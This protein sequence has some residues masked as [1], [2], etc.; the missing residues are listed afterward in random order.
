MITLQL[1][2]KPLHDQKVE[3]YVVFCEQDALLGKHSGEELKRF[4]PALKDIIEKRKFS[5]R[6]GSSLTLAGNEGDRSVML[7]F[8]GLGSKNRPQE[9]RIETYRRALGSLIRACEAAKISTLALDLPD[10]HWFDCDA[11]TIAKETAIITDMA[12]YHFDL[13]ITDADA[14]PTRN[15]EI[16]LCA[17]AILHDQLQEGIT[18]GQHIGFAVRQAR[19]WCDLPANKLNPVIMAEHAQRIAQAHNLK[20]TVFNEEQIIKMGMGGIAAV[21]K[22]SELDAALVIMEYK[23]EHPN[24]PT[25]ALVGK[26]ITFDTGGISIKPS[27]GMEAMKDDMA[28]AAAVIS[29]M[30]ALAHLKPQVNVIGIAPLAENMPSGSA[31]RPGDIITFYNGKTG[32]VKNT[33]AEGRLI[34]A[35]ALSYA[36]K[37]YKLD[38]IVEAATLTGS[39]SYALGPFYCGLM[40]KHQDLADAVLA[41][42]RRSGD[43][44]WQLPFHDDYKP[45]VKSTVADLCNDSSQ[46]YRAGAITAGFFLQAFVG[47]VPWVH[48]DIAGTSFNVPDISY[49]RPGATGFG[50]RL[51]VDLIMNWKQK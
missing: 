19:L 17:P 13:F 10:H 45:A 28:A 7:F 36:I 38:A 3:G 29:T 4:Y 49:Y 20:V 47:D 48:L 35:D 12:A 34:L 2:D 16:T 15:F 32:E 40:T 1:S 5:G 6:A 42:S 14:R 46:T 25:I 23:T 41:A 31:T 27:A 11:F 50:V 51:F 9:E 37:H 44:A 30:E 8:Y 33:D 26:G 39:C 24:A 18:Q 21:S 43:R 22:G